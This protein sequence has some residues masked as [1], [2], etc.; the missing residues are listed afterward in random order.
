M[1]IR[2]RLLSNVGLMLVLSLLF[3]LLLMWARSLTVRSVNIINHFTQ[4]ELSSYQLVQ[5][6]NDVILHPDEKRAVQ[7]WDKKLNSFKQLL[8]TRIEVSEQV[9]IGVGLLKKKLHELSRLHQR[10]VTTK[11]R[12][13]LSPDKQ[14]IIR[15][16]QNR[17]AVNISSLAQ[18]MAERTSQMRAALSAEYQVDM[19][20]LFILTL[21]ATLLVSVVLVFISIMV[22]R[23]IVR[24]IEVLSNGTLQV[25]HDD[26]NYRMQLDSKD[27]LQEY[28]QAFNNMMTRLDENMASKEVLNQEIEAHLIAETKLRKYRDSLE[29]KVKDRTEALEKSRMAAISI[30]EDANHQRLSAEQA[31]DATVK[32]N[33]ALEK[34]IRVREQVQKKLRENEASLKMMVVAADSANKAKST[35]LANMSHELRTPLNAILGFS[36][37]MSRDSQLNEQSK[38]QLAVINR[39]GEHLLNMINSVLDLSKIEAGRLEIV[40]EHC[41]LQQLINDIELMIAVQAKSKGLMFELESDPKLQAYVNVDSGKLRQILI[42]LLGNAL[43]FTEQGGISLRV[44]TRAITDDQQRVM[45]Y[46]EIEDSG[47]GIAED[48]LDSIFKPFVQAGSSSQSAKGTGLGLAITKSLIMLMDG[49]ISVKSEVNK[50]TLFSLQLPVQISKKA[51]I[52]AEEEVIAVITGIEENQPNWRILIVDD[53]SENRMLLKVLLTQVGF[54]VREAEDGKQAIHMFSEWH[55]DLIW[56]DINMP[57]INGYEA[58]KTIRKM[59]DGEKVKIIAITGSVFNE[60][61]ARIRDAGCD[62]IVRKPYRNHEIYEIL[63]NVLGVNFIYADANT[64][65]ADSEQIELKS[66]ASDGLL[67][68]SDEVADKLAELTL[69]LD[70]EAFLAFLDSTEELN[71]SLKKNIRNMLNEFRFDNINNLLQTRHDSRPE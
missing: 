41:D 69:E 12:F 57:V 24:G 8:D 55:P 6:T 54:H 33:K 5:L 3:I 22:V 28:A 35:F 39:S 27:E 29:Q 16:H 11:N 62:G 49:Q 14:H 45:L 15:K 20:R 58:T 68:I 31:R 43:K 44:N 51:L 19:N 66:D 65:I 7:Q 64:D 23:S 52:A 2:Y 25:T 36:E 4:I 13:K 47:I 1:K 30:M 42:N 67:Q 37:I 71:D 21:L 10:L 46:I 38:E 32:A 56:M 61:K 48:K 9:S 63:K 40:P 26:L 50:G 17:I 59:E 60:Q 70:R 53:S 34:E 18:D